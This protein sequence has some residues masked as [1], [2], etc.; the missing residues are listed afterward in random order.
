MSEQ[1]L[2]DSQQIHIKELIAAAVQWCRA[3]TQIWPKQFSL[4][5]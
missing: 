1:W 3:E 5:M 4:L 2:D